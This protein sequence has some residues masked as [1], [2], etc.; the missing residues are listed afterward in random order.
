MFS[1]PGS[2]QKKKGRWN[3]TPNWPKLGRV[4]P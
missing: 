4:S 3:T 1:L 2:R